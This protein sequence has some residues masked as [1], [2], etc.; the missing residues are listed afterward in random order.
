MSLSLQDFEG[1]NLCIDCAFYRH[2]K[3][4]P[5]ASRFREHLGPTP[6]LHQD[7]QAPGFATDLAVT[8]GLASKSSKAAGFMK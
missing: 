3:Q 4:D 1:S 7:S 8:A 2:V 6:D 5:A